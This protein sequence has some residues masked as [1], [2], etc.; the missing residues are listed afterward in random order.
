[1]ATECYRQL[2]FGFQPQLVVDF[3]GGT[4][5]TDA[6]LVPRPDSSRPGDRGGRPARCHATSPCPTPRS[7]GRTSS[8]CGTRSCTTTSAFEED[9][10]WQVDTGDLPTLVESLEPLVP[11]TP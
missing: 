2:G 1:M 5:T 10:V 11:P 4:L 8:G 9:I 6:G 7:P 3:A